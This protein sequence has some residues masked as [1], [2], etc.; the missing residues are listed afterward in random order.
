M[1]FLAR[2]H[3]PPCLLPLVT[4][5]PTAA[6]TDLLTPSLW[7]V[8]KLNDSYLQFYFSNILFCE[9]LS[10]FSQELSLLLRL[11]WQTNPNLRITLLPRLYIQGTGPVFMLP[12]DCS[13]Y[14]APP[15]GFTS[16]P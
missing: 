1:L 12:E 16:Q 14:K 13:P 15:E 7:V 10:P 4:P 9:N 5:I 3:A 6:N 2:L 8:H 11:E